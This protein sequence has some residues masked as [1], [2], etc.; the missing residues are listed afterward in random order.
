MYINIVINTFY[1]AST[2]ILKIPS[3]LSKYI[4]PVCPWNKTENTALITVE[5]KN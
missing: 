4:G 2:F 5:K 1:I 3:F